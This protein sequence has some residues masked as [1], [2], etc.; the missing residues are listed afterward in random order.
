MLINATSRE[1][2]FPQKITVLYLD[3]TIH[4]WG[5]NKDDLDTFQIF[6]LRNT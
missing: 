6:C 4:I 2:L 5:R 1:K 3:D